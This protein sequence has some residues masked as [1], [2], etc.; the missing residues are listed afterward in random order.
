VGGRYAG[1]RP[2]HTRQNGVGSL[3]AC[4][5]SWA[6]ADPFRPPILDLLLGETGPRSLVLLAKSVKLHDFTQPKDGGNDLG[7]IAGTPKIRGDDY[8]KLSWGTVGP[9]AGGM[10]PRRRERLVGPTLAALLVVPTGRRVAHQQQR[11]R[12]GTRV[13]CPFVLGGSR[14]PDE[15]IR[16]AHAVR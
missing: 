10:L 1:K 14:V 8:V 5:S 13:A 7:G 12:P 15:G 11:H 2:E 6:L 9:H 16:S 4:R 3:S